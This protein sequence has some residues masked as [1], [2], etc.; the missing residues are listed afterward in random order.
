MQHF[1]NGWL[2]PTSVTN[3]TK[4]VTFLRH[5]LVA[6]YFIQ[7]GWYSMIWFRQRLVMFCLVCI[8][9]WNFIG[10]LC[11]VIENIFCMCLFIIAVIFHHVLFLITRA[12]R[13]DRPSPW[14][15]SEP[16]RQDIGH[17]GR[18]WIFIVKYQCCLNFVVVLPSTQ[19]ENK[20]RWE[21]LKSNGD[22]HSFLNLKKR[23]AWK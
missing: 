23:H 6:F 2:P 10:Y 21:R 15:R 7:L 4:N 13:T 20:W 5:P 8:D 11:R 22:G 9:S 19:T 12:S 17:D 3:V 18:P 14:F 1:E 16:T